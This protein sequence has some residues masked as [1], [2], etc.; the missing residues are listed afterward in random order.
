MPDRILLTPKE[1]A[2]PTAFRLPASIARTLSGLAER[3]GRTKTELVLMALEH[4]LQ[5]VEVETTTGSP[6]HPDASFR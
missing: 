6:A 3:T 1:P 4:F 5:C 2:V